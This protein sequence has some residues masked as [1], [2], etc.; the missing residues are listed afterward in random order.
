MGEQL[1]IAG[2]RVVG[3]QVPGE[4]RRQ[5]TEPYVGAGPVTAGQRQ[6]EDQL[7]TTDRLG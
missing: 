6:L 5:V 2:Q 4:Q 3:G 7:A 1:R